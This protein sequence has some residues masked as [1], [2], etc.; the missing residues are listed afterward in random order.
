MYKTMVPLLYEYSNLAYITPS[1]FKRK[2]GVNIG[3]AEDLDR[4]LS[5]VINWKL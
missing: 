1:L 4:I 5:N 3:K 2:F